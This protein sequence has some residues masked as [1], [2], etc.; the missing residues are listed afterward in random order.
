[1]GG[2]LKREGRL[3]QEFNRKREMKR[4]REGGWKGGRKN[5]N[6]EKERDSMK[7]KQSDVMELWD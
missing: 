2:T 1:M 4:G 7:R 3:R 5:E 6:G